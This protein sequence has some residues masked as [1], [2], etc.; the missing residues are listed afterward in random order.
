MEQNRYPTNSLRGY[1]V[2]GAI[3]LSQRRWSHDLTVSF[4]MTGFNNVN[5]HGI[6]VHQFGDLSRSCQ[7]LGGHFNPYGSAHQGSRQ[8]GHTHGHVGD[9]GN[10]YSD[11]S[12]RVSG[13][14]IMHGTSLYGRTSI[15]GRSIV[16]HMRADD[17]GHGKSAGSRISGNAGGRLACCVIAQR[18]TA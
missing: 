7:S 15:I 6:H 17:L 18:S 9:W 12:G 3:L 11:R 16:I 14:K 8:A 13:R 5:A 1:N 4:N 2:R 10:I